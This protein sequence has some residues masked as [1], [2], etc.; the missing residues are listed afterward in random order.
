MRVPLTRGQYATFVSVYAP[1]LC[2]LEKTKMAFYQGLRQ[3]VAKIPPADEVVILADFNARVVKDAEIWH[4]LSKH[5]VVK[6]ISNGLILLQ[7]CMEMGFQLTNT[8]FQMKNKLK[9]T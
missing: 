2:T 5:G 4:V 9:T 3:L 8:M 6:L 7:F 1:T